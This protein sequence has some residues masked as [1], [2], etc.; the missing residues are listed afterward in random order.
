MIGDTSEA[1][2]SG[3]LCELLEIYQQHV[4]LASQ[5]LPWYQGDP[6][7][8]LMI[9]AQQCSTSRAAKGSASPVRRSWQ[10]LIEVKEGRRQRAEFAIKTDTNS[11]INDMNQLR[12][13]FSF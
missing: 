6:Q 8:M 1:E 5:L 3:V 4:E 12:D 2:L 7:Y 10:G 11:A 9:E 13:F